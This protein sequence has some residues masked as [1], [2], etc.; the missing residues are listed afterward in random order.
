[1]KKI[2]LPVILSIG[3]ATVVPAPAY[4]I[5]TEKQFCEGVNWSQL[6]A[7]GGRNCAALKKKYVK[8]K[9]PRKKADETVRSI[10]KLLNELGY[11]AGT[12]DGLYGRKTG[13]ALTAFYNSIG[14]TYDGKAD[15][16]ELAVLKDFAANGAAGSTQPAQGNMDDIPEFTEPTTPR[17][18]KAEVPFNEIP[19]EFIRFKRGENDGV[20]L[21]AGSWMGKDPALMNTA[22]L[23]IDND[24]VAE[25]AYFASDECENG[26]CMYQIAYYYDGANGAGWKNVFRG[27]GGDAF[28]AIKHEDR[29]HSI[30]TG[31]QQLD[32]D[33]QRYVVSEE[34]WDILEGLRKVNYTGRRVTYDK[35]VITEKKLEKVFNKNAFDAYSNDFMT[36]VQGW[37]YILKTNDEKYCDGTG[38]VTMCNFWLLTS[39]NRV[40]SEGVFQWGKNIKYK[41]SHAS[42]KFMF[43]GIMPSDPQQMKSKVVFE[44][45]NGKPM[46][47]TASNGEIVFADIQ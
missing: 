39:D 28:I 24:G 18:V 19:E 25:I 22:I 11:N 27:Y 29:V 26:S 4:A 3:A 15:A 9:R 38:E 1:M 23:D 12:A 5:F 34:G 21:L 20:G 8:P 32:W 37:E 16:E 44:M 46:Q 40:I 2:V 14:L 31:G 13:N 45:Y 30:K 42:V 7:Y 47:L 36:A 6:F 43:D 41:K 10:Q 33:G 35:D 17:W